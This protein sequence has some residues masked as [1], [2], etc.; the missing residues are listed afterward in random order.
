MYYKLVD[1]VDVPINLSI[2]RRTG[3]AVRYASIR[4][5]P[6]KKYEIP[7][8]E[9]FDQL[10]K[11]KQKIPYTASAEARLQ[12][13]GIKYEKKYCKVC[14]NRNALKLEYNVIEVID[15]AKA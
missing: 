8:K 13:L 6:G 10:L 14:G 1:A 2:V 4:H 12:E 9:I 7:E 3:S 5:E 15:D 11:A